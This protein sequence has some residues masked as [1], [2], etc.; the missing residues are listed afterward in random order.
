MNQAQNINLLGALAL[1]LADKQLAAAQKVSGISA[2][3]CAA[4]VT[5]GPHPGST[6]GGI[7]KVA[8]LTHSVMVRT[9]EHLIELGLVERR[10]GTDRRVVTLRLTPAGTKTRAAILKARTAALTSA[11][12]G[13][14]SSEQIQLG[15]LVSKMLVG[16]TES[17]AE[18]NHLCRLCD[19]DVCCQATCPVERETCRIENLGG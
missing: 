3:A 19:E 4:L 13:L 14:S 12:K 1:T 5:L 2:S 8:G 17:R 16:V 9:V 6:I 7:A 11:L 15:K 18:A 10:P